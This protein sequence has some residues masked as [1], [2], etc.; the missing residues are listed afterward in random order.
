M[1]HWQARNEIGVMAERCHMMLGMV[2]SAMSMEKDDAFEKEY[3]RVEHYEQ[4]TDNM[5]V[6]IAEY[7]RKVSEGRLSAYSKN[8]ITRMLREVDELEM[9]QM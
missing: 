4:I 2:K 1:S 5:E 6:E 7:L 9:E 8:H 3:K